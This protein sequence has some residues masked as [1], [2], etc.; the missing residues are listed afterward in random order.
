MAPGLRGFFGEESSCDGESTLL[1]GDAVQKLISLYKHALMYIAC[2]LY[3]PIPVQ[4]IEYFFKASQ[5]LIP[6]YA[7]KQKLASPTFYC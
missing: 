6:T 7:V 5:I 4:T 2:A 1:L 3:R